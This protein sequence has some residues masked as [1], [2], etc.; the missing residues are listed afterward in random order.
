MSVLTLD[1]GGTK[2]AAAIVSDGRVEGMPLS[3]ATP[4]TEGA[5]AVLA[6][7]VTAARRVLSRPGGESPRPGLV[8]VSSAGVIDS[9]TGVV[10]H[11]TDLIR[12][13]A[14][15]RLA[16]RLQDA[17]GMPA[18]CLNDVHA[19]ALGEARYGAGRQVRSMLLVAVGTGIGGAHVVE[20]QVLVGDHF[21]AGHVGHVTVPEAV[22]Q[23]CS[24]GRT[25]HLEA[26][27][28]GSAVLAAYR[29]LSG[30]EATGADLGDALGDAGSRGDAAR[31]VVSAAGYATGRAIGSLV[32]VLDPGLVV[33][34]GGLTRAGDAWLRP[35]TEGVLESALDALAG[36]P[37]V[38]AVT[39]DAAPHLGA[40]AFALQKA[41]S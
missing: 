18:H 2:I 40:A 41:G 34:S 28:S 14:G 9:D 4:A 13:W 35:L 37:V 20:G 10:T 32:N 29:R 5:D 27:A 3:V 19:H 7:C 39:G 24:C 17:L 26:V 11:A 22:D 38:P 30:T 23:P 15:A 6:A 12:G 31:A 21:A 8:G 36:I 33:L 25:G 1:I 16:E